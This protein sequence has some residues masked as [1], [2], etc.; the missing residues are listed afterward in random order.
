MEDGLT[1]RTD[2]LLRVISG[3]WGAN[4]KCGVG[5]TGQTESEWQLQLPN[6]MVGQVGRVEQEVGGRSEGSNRKWVA[7]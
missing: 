4:R 6:G 5:G 3:G 7:G 2:L 1:V